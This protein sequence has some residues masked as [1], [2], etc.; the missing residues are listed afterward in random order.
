MDEY[1]IYCLT[2]P[3]GKKY[4]G[5]TKQRVY[6]RW[7]PSAYSH[8]K[9]MYEDIKL[10]GWEEITKE[11]LEIVNTSEEADEREDYFISLYDT[12][13]QE[14]GYNKVTNSTHGNIINKNEVLKLWNEGKSIGEIAEAFSCSSH[15]IGQILR[16]EGISKEERNNRGTPA[17]NKY[18]NKKLAQYDLQDNLLNIFPSLSEAS[19]ITGYNKAA[20][21]RC[22]KDK[23]KTSYCYKWRYIENEE[24]VNELGTSQET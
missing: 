17:R 4:V 7:R 19:R 6:N 24:Q 2:F 9:K 14:K 16:K 8:N 18:K 5:Q 12:T 15:S 10:Y 11:V 3:N 21:S 22:C 23:Q 13:N 1:K 20:I